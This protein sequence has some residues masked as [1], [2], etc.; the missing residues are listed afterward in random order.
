MTWRELLPW[1]YEESVR[2]RVLLKRVADKMMK[3]ELVKVG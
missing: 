2:I 3:R 1:P